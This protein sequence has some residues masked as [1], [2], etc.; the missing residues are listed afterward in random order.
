MSADVPDRLAAGLGLLDRQ[1]VDKKDNSVAK[2]DDLELTIDRDGRAYVSAF[3]CGPGALA[4]RI[5]GRLG[6]W[7]TALW[8]RLH[9]DASPSPVRIPIG[10]MNKLDAAV[11]LDVDRDATG[12]QALNAWFAVHIIE[13]IPGADHGDG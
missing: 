11:H 13:P 10:A 12:T 8:R 1:I 7:I 5:G 3:L 2:V 6:G 4:P 9:P